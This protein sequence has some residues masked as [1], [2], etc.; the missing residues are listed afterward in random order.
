[1]VDDIASAQFQRINA[2]LLRSRVHRGLAS[3][4]LDHPGAAIGDA[5]GRVAVDRPYAPAIFRH[6]IGAGENARGEGR[7]AIRRDHRVAAAVRCQIELP[8]EQNSIRIEGEPDFG[9]IV[10]RLAGDHQILGPVL[11]PLDR[12]AQDFRGCHHRQ[13][14]AVDECFQAKTPAHIVG[15]D[16]DMRLLEP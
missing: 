16:T 1:M 7:F 10:P 12:P 6:A 2:K 8:G 13:F 4:R 3:Q 9:Q 5:A 11:Y 14:V 15:D